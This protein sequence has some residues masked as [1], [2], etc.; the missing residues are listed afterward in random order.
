MAA[1]H[2]VAWWAFLDASID[3]NPFDDALL[4]AAE[5]IAHGAPA[6]DAPAEEIAD[7]LRSAARAW[8]SGHR[9]ASPDRVGS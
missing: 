7:R 6:V 8:I 5:R 2:G 4:D 9:A 3:A 1:L